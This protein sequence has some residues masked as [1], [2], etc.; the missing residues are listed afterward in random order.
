MLICKTKCK[1]FPITL[2]V[3]LL[4]LF[5]ACDKPPVTA[6]YYAGGGDTTEICLDDW[7]V[8]GPFTVRQDSALMRD[9]AVSHRL[10]LPAERQDTTVK[11]WHNGAYHPRY[12]QLDLR[13]VFGIGVTDT[14]RILE[15]TVTYLSCT[16]KS[17]KDKN[18][19]LHVNTRMR[20]KGYVNGDSLTRIDI[21][22]MDIYPVHLKAGD[23]TLLV[24]TQGVKGKYWYEATLYD[25]TR[26]A[27]LYAE[28]HT[29]NIVYPVIS[30]DSIVLTDNHQTITNHSIKLFFSDAYG[31]KTPEMVL[32]KGT[33]K[34]HVP[35][36]QKDRAYICSM[37]MG[38]DTV[39]QPVMTYAIDG[40][41][42]RF[43]AMRDSLPCGHPRL[44]E[45]DQLRYR[46]WKLGTVSGKMREDRWFPFKMPWLAYQLEHIFAHIDGTYGNDDDEY[47]FKFL[48][49]RSELDGCLQR[50]I[51]VTPNNVDRGRKYP[52]VV[53]M[54][55]CSEKRYH[56]F[57]SPQISHQFVVNDLQVVADR[58][59]SFVIMPEARM[60]LNEDLTPFADTEMRL[61]IA[62]A[63]E[64][65]NIDP[66]RIYLHANCSGGYRALRFAAYNPD[67]FAAIAL[68]APVYRRN[69]GENVNMACAPE[70]MLAN[71]R[72]VPLLIFG[73]PVD[74]HSPVSVYAD[75]LK[76]CDRHHIPYRLALRRNSGQGYHGYHRLL[77]GRE[78][79]DFFKDKSRAHRAHVKYRFPVNDTTVA[80]FYRRPF[81][82]VYNAV[83]TS[84]VYRRLV[85]DVRREY[86]SYLY[87]RLPI[88][89]DTVT[90]RM[91]LVP[92]TRV[93]HRMLAEKN[94]FLIGEDFGCH[95]VM[96]FAREV[97]KGKPRVRAEEVM[98]T[99]TE[100]PY[101]S[102]GM[103]LLYTSGRGSRFKHLIS[104]PWRHGFRRTMIK[105][106]TKQ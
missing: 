65:Y 43:T 57:F 94:V 25:S 12:G 10:S 88:D 62:D 86:E 102:G 96:A 105:E 44:D 70:T 77:V 87:S 106:Q 79:C 3:I 16:I 22:D 83:D 6:V 84:A 26:M 30:N 14:T 50:Y 59:G 24:R 53:V 52:L 28:E 97:A 11:L 40:V 47:N 5:H 89:N 66:D 55:P 73:D 98:L 20:C 101:N 2:G 13:E 80:D 51:L 27:G 95:N 35:A 39:R 1:L 99:A 64:H 68:Y 54:R 23:N 93:T 17:D 37:V 76:D 9:F 19:F 8:Y 18:L 15:R 69:D 29:G 56:L 100:N 38:G 67:M 33:V 81:I 74:T 92:D 32:R 104:Y 31:N 48:T 103:A 85:A 41:E 78:A 90:C 63:Q 45:I 61:A 91:P 75:L 36:L 58:Y 4:L 21:K 60:M 72:N 49:Y 42:P 46:V 71:L 82:Y 7:N 34:Y